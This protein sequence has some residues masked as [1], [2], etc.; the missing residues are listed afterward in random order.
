MFARS[1]LTSSGK[2]LD[3]V[4][5]IRCAVSYL[6]A[7]TQVFNFTGLSQTRDCGHAHLEQTR[8]LPFCIDLEPRSICMIT[9]LA[10]LL[11]SSC[12]YRSCY[13]QCVDDPSFYLEKL[14]LSGG[15][16]LFAVSF[17]RRIP[18]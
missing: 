13:A 4:E 15:K 12:Q 2:R 10:M 14:L 3:H 17:G 1:Q 7:N 11:L 5:E 8:K 9:Q 6:I 16:T 18:L